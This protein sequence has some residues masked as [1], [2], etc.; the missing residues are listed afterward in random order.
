MTCLS[1]SNIVS[2]GALV[3]SL[4]FVPLVLPASAQ[5]SA[6]TNSSP[7]TTNSAQTT[8]STRENRSPDWGWLGL[9][10]L[11]GLAGLAGRKREEPTR[12]QDPNVSTGTNIR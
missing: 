10:G 9:T 6:G 3:T 4:A 11:L 8:E 5:N 1:L 2:T 12:Y 7:S